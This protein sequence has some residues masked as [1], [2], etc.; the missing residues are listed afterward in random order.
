MV[1][2]GVVDSDLIWFS[3]QKKRLLFGDIFTLFKWRE[4]PCFHK[5]QRSCRQVNLE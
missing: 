3:L 5:R 4:H 1:I 2:D